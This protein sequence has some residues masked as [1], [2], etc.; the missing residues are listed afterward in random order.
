MKHLFAALLSLS[1]IFIANTATAQS[2]VGVQ[3]FLDGSSATQDLGDADLGAG[4]GFEANLTYRFLPRLSA[5]GGW[6]WQ[7]F[8]AEESFAGAEADFEETGYRFGLQFMRPL[9]AT[10]IDY[11]V[12]AGGIYNHIE[13]E[14]SDGDITAD[15]GHGLGWQVGAGVAVPI[16]AKWRLMPG[17]RYQS[18]SR[19]I[20]IGATTTDADLTYVA[21]EI[22]FHRTF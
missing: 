19:D 6:G 7:R 20:E 9:G 1:L 8:S 4:F 18:L 2:R 3:L 16:G 15:S 10:P 13:I 21:L 17:L 11:F 12:R 22:G 5:Y 14:N